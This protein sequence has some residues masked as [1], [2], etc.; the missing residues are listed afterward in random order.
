MSSW[1]GIA[2][3]HEIVS[4]KLDNMYDFS[5]RRINLDDPKI[6]TLLLNISCL[7][8]FGGRKNELALTT[9]AIN[10]EENHIFIL[11]LYTVLV[12]G[13]KSM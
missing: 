2:R 3:H 13:S 8:N 10:I 7:S 9:V 1:G 6:V 11:I 5:A 4:R 12:N